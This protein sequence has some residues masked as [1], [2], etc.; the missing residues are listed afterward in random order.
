MCL[1][2]F[3]FNTVNP[4]KPV[5]GVEQKLQWR[6]W[7]KRNDQQENFWCGGSQEWHRAEH[8]GYNKID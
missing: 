8:E 3:I 2:F 6:L 7:E 4:C 5:L 1:P